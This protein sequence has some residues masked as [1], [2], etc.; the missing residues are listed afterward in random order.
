MQVFGLPAL[1]LQLGDSIEVSGVLG[2]F[3]GEL[4][5][6]NPVVAPNRKSG[7]TVPAPVERSTGAIA[8][9][10]A[11]TGP[12]LADIGR[13]LIVRRATVGAF[14]TQSGP[15]NAPLNDGSGAIAIRLDGNVATTIPRSTFAAGK[16]YDIVGILGFFNGTPQLK[17]RMLSDVAE[18]PCQ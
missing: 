16:C 10:V 1:G 11:A 5:V 17:P 14:D 7:V 4:Q 2:Q 3:G 12:R 15:G 8:A 13:L 9:G 18:V 6:I